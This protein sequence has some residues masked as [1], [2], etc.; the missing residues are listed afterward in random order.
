MVTKLPFLTWP[1]NIIHYLCFLENFIFLKST[2]YI[3]SYG[4]LNVWC[5]KRWIQ[6]FSTEK[7]LSD[8]AFSIV[9]QAPGGA[10]AQT[11]KIK[12]NIYRLKWNFAWVIIFIKTFLM[13]NLG[14]IAL[15][16][17]EI[18]RHKISLERREQVIKFC[19]LPPEN[20]FNFKKNEGFFQ[21]RSCQSKIDPLMSI[22]AIF[23]QRKIFS[24][25]KF[26]GCLDKKRA[27]AN[28][29]IDQFC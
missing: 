9:R 7:T 26:L 17:L 2:L 1:R 3:K 5:Y 18:W 28:P 27:A 8:P 21:N 4:H 15:L 23:K 14:L 6:I 10:E 13:Q 11:S 19:Y 20:R 16:G 25:S 24:F 29:L 22:S 12:V